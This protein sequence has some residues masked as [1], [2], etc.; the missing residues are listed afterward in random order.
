MSKRSEIEKYGLDSF[1][2]YLCLRP[3]RLLIAC[4]VF[5][6]RG[7]L[8]L[9]A[10]GIARGIPAILK[11]VVDADTLWHDA[12]A[13]IPAVLVLYALAAR[14]PSAPA[15]VRVVWRYGRG[16]MSLSAIA[17]VALTAAQLGADPKRWLASSAAAKGL[18][19]A[20]LAVFCYVL[21]SDRVRQTFLDFPSV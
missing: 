17:Y 20:E 11:G 16:L 4:L 12:A 9:A 7:L 8:V 13:S 1:D 6:C 21:L 10:F 19:V 3:S 15:F 5:L 14:L 2:D 18:V